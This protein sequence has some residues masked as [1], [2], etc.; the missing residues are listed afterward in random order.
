MRIQTNLVP[1]AFLACAC[2]VLR[3]AEYTLPA[4]P[5]TL[6]WGD[7]SA[8]AKPALKVHSGDTVRMQTASSCPPPAR[9]E[10]AGVRPSDI[11]QYL[12][13]IHETVKDKRPGGHILTGPV[14]IEEAE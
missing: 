3:A 13:H 14:P 6:V 10:A 7:Y 8:Q 4:T 9:L 1:T 5:S 11:P 2:C 12:R